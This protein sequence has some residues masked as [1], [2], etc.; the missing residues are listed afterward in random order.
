[1]QRRWKFYEGS[2]ISIWYSYSSVILYFLYS[3]LQVI[4]SHTWFLF[5]HSDIFDSSPEYLITICISKAVKSLKLYSLWRYK[6]CSSSNAEKKTIP[7]HG[8]R[9]GMV[10]TLIQSSL[11]P[12]LNWNAIISK[13]EIQE[14]VTN[15]VIILSRLQFEPFY[16]SQSK[17]KNRKSAQ[18]KRRHECQ[19]ARRVLYL[20]R[21]LCHETSVMA[22]WLQ[23]VVPCLWNPWNRNSCCTLRDMDKSMYLSPFIH[24]SWIVR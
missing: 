7:K 17:K 18:D 5:M 22:I 8:I 11:D 4:D 1:M 16:K 10:L 15:N 24:I 19:I 20:S 6:K 12:I 9:I 2:S 21:K 14:I 23:G 13:D 3:P